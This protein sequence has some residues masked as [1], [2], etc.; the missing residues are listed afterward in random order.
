[1]SEAAAAQVK[2]DQ[3]PM[4]PLLILVLGA[5]MAILD[6]S[7]VNVAIPKMMAIFGSTTDEIE[8]VLTGYML[9]SGMVVPI[10]G[11][12]GDRFGNKRMYILSLIIFTAG[13]ALC[14]LAWSCN[15]LIAFRVLQ[16]LGGGM[17]MPVTMGMIYRIVPPSKIGTALGI[18]GI[19]AIMGPAIGPTLGGY[20]VDN[21]TW[22]WIFTINIPIGIVTCIIAGI[23]LTET[24]LNKNLKPDIL[25]M[26]FSAGACFALLLA[27]DQGQKDGWTSQYIVTLFVVSVFLF[28][29]FVVWEL[30]HPHPLIDLRLLKNP[31]MV[32]SLLATA[33]T[34]IGLYS[35]VYLIPLFAQNIRGYTPMESGLM[36]MPAS[37]VTGFMMPVSGKLFDK[38][39]TFWPGLVGLI[40]L[41]ATTYHLN[42]IDMNTSFGAIQWMLSLRAVGLGLCMM[43]ITT[44]GMNT[45]PRHLVNRASAINNTIRQI[46]GSLGIAYLTYIWIDRENFHTQWLKEGL[47]AASPYAVVTQQKLEGFFSLHGLVGTSS[48]YGTDG[49][50]AQLVGQQ[51]SISGIDDAFIISAL[52]MLVVIPMLFLLTKKRVEEQRKIEL[53]RLG[54]PPAPPAAEPKAEGTPDPVAEH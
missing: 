11:Y 28:V 43:P 27:L 41:I 20:L 13:S 50:L 34:T 32:S 5:F 35:V 12:L 47:S 36:M 24:P 7:I 16:A 53:R 30:D 33:I 4:A 9:T 10:T 37:L 17:I 25:G 45:I 42:V 23:L 31:V 54:G 2:K 51:A 52:I 38:Y 29:A 48:V 19:G 40:I 21:F 49:V 18:W 1:M 46:A 14:G 44:A 3:I 39:G 8:W 26:V 6:S 15:S 22:R